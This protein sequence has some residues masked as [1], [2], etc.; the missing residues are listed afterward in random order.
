M[1]ATRLHMVELG[2]LDA[3]VMSSSNRGVQG[4]EMVMFSCNM[5]V[6]ARHYNPLFCCDE[7]LKK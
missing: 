6:Q 5:S 2:E 3:K 1:M 7:Q 4:V